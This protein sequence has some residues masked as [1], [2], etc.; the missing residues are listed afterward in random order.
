[1]TL[2][3]LWSGERRVPFGAAQ[4]AMDTVRAPLRAAL[5]HGNVHVV[6]VV[7]GDAAAV[8]HRLPPRR[9][10]PDVPDPLPIDDV[11]DAEPGR[12]RLG[13]RGDVVAPLHIGSGWHDA[14]G[15]EHEVTCPAE[16]M[17]APDLGAEAADGR[18]RAEPP[19][20]LVAHRAHARGDAVPA[21]GW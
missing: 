19:V 4:N 21:D 11:H 14:A 2:S 12:V 17:L 5:E 16:R 9:R 13:P 6:E 18:E 15:A 1:A 7:R 20:D 8:L 3:A 10:V